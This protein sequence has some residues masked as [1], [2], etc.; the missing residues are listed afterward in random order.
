MGCTGNRET[1]CF[2]SSRSKKTSTGK[3]DTSKKQEETRPPE[4]ET[5]KREKEKGKTETERNGNNEK[6]NEER[7]ERLGTKFV[8]L[9][10]S[11]LEK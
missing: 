4:S 7:L 9:E 2:V 1:I 11:V 8:F 6:C 3:E 10:N 5:R